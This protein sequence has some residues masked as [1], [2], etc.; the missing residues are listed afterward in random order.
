MTTRHLIPPATGAKEVLKVNVYERS[1]SLN[2]MLAPLFP[3]LGPGA[4]VV[5]AA[6]QRGIPGK[7]YGQFFHELPGGDQLHC[8]LEHGHD[9]ARLSDVRRQVPR[10]QC[11]PER[12]PEP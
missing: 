11:C 4:I 7:Q 10:R 6:L 8:G 5:T 2:C 1:I 3:Y 9:A 12:Q